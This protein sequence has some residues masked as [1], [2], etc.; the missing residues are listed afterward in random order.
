MNTMS[1]ILSGGGTSRTVEI[2]EEEEDKSSTNG[3]DEKSSGFSSTLS[4]SI[5]TALP[6]LPLNGEE[7]RGLSALEDREEDDDGQSESVSEVDN[8]LLIRDQLE[9]ISMGLVGLGHLVLRET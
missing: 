3:N 6:S 1:S 2:L 8:D 4:P 7:E 5:D 9:A